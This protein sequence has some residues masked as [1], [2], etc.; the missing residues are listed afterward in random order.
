MVTR[1]A[2][3]RAPSTPQ[4]DRPGR[5]PAGARSARRVAGDARVG[6]ARSAT[7]TTTDWQ[8]MKAVVDTDR[9]RP[10]SRRSS[11]SS[12][13]RHDDLATDPRRKRSSSGSAP[14]AVT[15][16]RLARQRRRG[17][18]CSAAARVCSG[19]S[20]RPTRRRC[21]SRCS[22]RTIRASRAQAVAALGV[23]QDPAAARAIHT[24]LRAATGEVRRAVIE[25]L[26][27]ERDPRVVPMLVADP[28]G[29]PAARQGSRGR[30]RDDRG[31]G[32]GRHRR[33]GADSRDHGA[34][35]SGSS[36]AGS[37]ARSRIA[38]S[39]R[40]RECSTDRR[41]RRSRTPPTQRRPATLKKIAR[42][43]L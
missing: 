5:L 27:A 20:A 28:R 6:R 26:V 36:A 41:R 10:A 38:A 30:A 19:G 23:I 35:R 13:S 7:S 12:R 1:G 3:R 9:R 25:A 18:S 37:C 22:A 4:S 17:G 15:A 21:C 34:A 2:A 14:K 39:T 33:G 42:A 29:E 40:W 11:R 24:V 31:A 16:P 43:R 32:H 8:A